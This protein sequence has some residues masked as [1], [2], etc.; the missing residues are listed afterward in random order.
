MNFDDAVDSLLTKEIR[1][2]SLDHGKQDAALNVERG[3]RK[4]KGRSKERGRSHNKLGGCKGI[5]YHHYGKKVYIKHDCYERKRQ[6][7]EQNIHDQ[8]HNLQPCSM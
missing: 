6:Q 8:V 5:E 7:K 2:K 3:R 1:K 4:F